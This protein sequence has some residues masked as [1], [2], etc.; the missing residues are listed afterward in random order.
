MTLIY[1]YIELV[2]QG[3]YMRNSPHRIEKNRIKSIRTTHAT[4]K[5]ESG[6]KW[7]APPWKIFP[8]LFKGKFWINYWHTFKRL[9][10]K[11][12]VSKR[13]H[14]KRTTPGDSDLPL[15]HEHVFPRRAT[16]FMKHNPLH[17]NRKAS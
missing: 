1:F 14:S 13:K 6:K 15:L 11:R 17:K 9:L 12:D 10:Q 3:G 4:K 16:Q 5:T 2:N 7:K 8:N